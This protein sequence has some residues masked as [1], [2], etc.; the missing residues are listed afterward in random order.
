MVKIINEMKLRL[1]AKSVNEAVARSCVSAFVAELSPTVEELGDLRCAVSE[2]VTNSIVHGYKSLPEGQVGNIYI[3]VRLYENRE[4][5]VEIS[6]NGC[7]IEDVARARE[8]MFTTGEYGDRCGMGFLVM[9]SF[10]DFLSVKSR[11]GKGTRVLM[12]KKLNP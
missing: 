2:A 1:P 3:S 11:P 8:P 7:G 5:T 4:V 12:R 10:T 9:E 6:D